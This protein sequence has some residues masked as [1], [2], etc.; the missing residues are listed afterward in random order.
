VSITKQ[1]LFLVDEKRRS[2]VDIVVEKI[3]ELLIK[4][5][6]APGEMIPSEQVLA[7]GLKVSRGS[8]R[9]AMKILSAFGIVD[10]RRGDGTYISTPANEKL[11]DPLLFQILVQDRDYESLIEIRQLLEE[12]ILRLLIKKAGDEELEQISRCI[13]EFERVLKSKESTTEECNALDLKYHQM[14]GDFSHNGILNSIYHF[15]IEIF[16]P[17]INSKQP[18]VIAVHRELHEALITRNEDAALQAI[19]KH[20]EIWVNANLRPPTDAPAIAAVD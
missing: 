10:I 2:T 18:G 20:T 1:E 14:L 9:E 13:A 15:I 11:F 17:T 5:Q 6:I 19:R 8:V 7:D 4:Q 16:S 12:G 3:K